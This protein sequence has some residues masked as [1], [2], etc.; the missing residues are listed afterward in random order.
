[1]ELTEKDKQTFRGWGYT[2]SDMKQLEEAAARCE[3]R[4]Q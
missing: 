4:K 1:M 3:Y 2:E